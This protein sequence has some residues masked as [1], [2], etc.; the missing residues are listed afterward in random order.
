MKKIF[1][2]ISLF[3]SI[4]FASCNAFYVPALVNT[5]MFEEKNETSINASVGTN[6]YNFQGAYSITNNLAFMAN[7][8]FIKK[9]SYGYHGE[10]L[11]V[12]RNAELGVGYYRKLIDEYKFELFSGI[13]YEE[14]SLSFNVYNNAENNFYK[15]YNFFI[16]PSFGA[17][18]NNIEAVFSL[19]INSLTFHSNSFSGKYRDLPYTAFFEPAFTIRYGY[20]YIKLFNQL[21]MSVPY[22]YQS[23]FVHNFTYNTGFYAY[24]FIYFSFGANIKIAPKYYTKKAQN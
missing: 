6:G 10:S 18:S 9:Q 12:S 22:L 17:T 5:P 23:L 15:K 16:Q 7:S 13:G 14:N 19:K 20:K 3:I 11:N 24:Q 1:H 21:G 4:A 8:K 2:I